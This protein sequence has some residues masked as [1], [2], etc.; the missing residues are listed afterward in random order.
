MIPQA[1]IFDFDGTLAD[2][3]PAITRGINLTMQ[4]YGF[5][6][7]TEAEVITFINNGPRMLIRR[8]L[9]KELQA[10]EEL[11][12]RVLADYNVFY[13][14]HCLNSDPPYE[15]IPE[16]VASLRSQGYRIGVLSNKQDHLLGPLCNSVI[17]GGYDATVGSLPDKPAKPDPYLSNKI[18]NLL[19]VEPQACIMIG[20]S[21]VDI[22]TAKNAG[23]THIGVSWGYR[24]EAVLRAHGAERVVHTAEELLREIDRIT[25]QR[26]DEN[27]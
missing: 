14:N 26:K 10:D 24:D 7:H 25:K 12:D 9:P 23:M 16:A 3:I 17:P 5:P 2:T 4:K 11:L 6:L 21:D 13:K 15:G 22:E 19:G 1:V 8:S 18:A 20:D 27:S